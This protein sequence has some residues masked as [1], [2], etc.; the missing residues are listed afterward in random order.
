MGRADKIMSFAKARPGRERAEFQQWFLKEYAARLTA[1]PGSRR[2]VV[3]LV[4]VTP[5]KV[6]WRRPD[7]ANPIPDAPPYDVVSEVWVDDAENFAM[8]DGLETW[9]DTLHAYRVSETI[10]K[11]EQRVTPGQRSPGA[12][13]IAVCVF[14]DDMSEA[15]ARRSW[16]HHVGLALKVHVGMSKYVRNWVEIPPEPG[17]PYAQGIVELHFPTMADLENRWFD[18]ESGRLQIVQDIG[19]FLKSG[20]RMFTSE[21]VLR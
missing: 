10:E 20:N 9:C 2:C 1:V 7:E 16:A 6:S 11:D 4:D 12:K 3:N 5:A 14:H 8:P 15:A 18:S 17:T 21:Y 13:Y 19:H